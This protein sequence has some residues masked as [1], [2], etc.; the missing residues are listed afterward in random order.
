MKAVILAGGRGERLRPIT[1]TRPKP[2]VP[3][4]ARPV[5]D[6]CLSLLS[7]YGV[8]E[9]Y[10]TTHYLA[11]QIRARYG[12]R[13]FGMQMHYSLEK[14]PMGTAGAVK[15]LEDVLCREE[16]FLV[17]SG[18]ALCDFDLEKALAFHKEKKA[19]ATMILS[20]VRTPM[21]YG[22]VLSDS[23]ERIFAFS[24]KPD[25]SETFSDRVNTG[26]YIL[27]PRVLGRVPENQKFD[28]SMDLFPTLLREGYRLFGYKDDGYWCDIGKVSTLYRCNRDLL[29]GK[30]RTWFEPYGTTKTSADGKGTY[31]VSDGARIDEGAV[32]GEGTVISPGVHLAE[33][34]R[35]DGSIIMEE[36]EVGK[37]ALVR[38]AILCEKTVL[39]PGAIAM[40]GSV[41]GAESRALSG[42][43]I[44]SG[45]R[46]PPSSKI[47]SAPPFYE[48]GLVFTEEGAAKE[49]G[50][51]L[52]EKETERLGFALATARQGQIGVFWEADARARSAALHFA[53]GV[54]RGGATACLFGEA[55][56]EVASFG[57]ARFLLPSAFICSGE[58]GTLIFVLEK[59]GFPLS[60]KEVLRLGRCHEERERRTTGGIETMVPIRESYCR[61][62]REMLGE[63]NQKAVSLVGGNATL[64]REAAIKA[65]FS[66][67][68]ER[69]EKGICLEILPETLRLFVNG[70]H[71]ADTERIR[72]LLVER[73]L[74]RG[75]RRF[76]LPDT[77]PPLLREHITARGGTAEQFT[78]SH[79]TKDES[80]LRRKGSEDRWLFDVNFLAAKLLREIKTLTTKEINDLILA[81]PE[82]YVSELRYYPKEDTKAK[83]LGR[84]ARLPEEKEVRIAPGFFAI[85]IISSAYRFEA[86]LDQAM[87]IRGKINEIEKEIRGD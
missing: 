81:T 73:E 32:I 42:A 18:D 36:T 66:A 48:E 33:G 78:L 74:K 28:F 8:Q 83:L 70:E 64:L 46:I 77:T 52:D 35:V 47:L 56:R 45:S 9:A 69:K 54:V 49:S 79:T 62:L 44:L 13:A 3:V 34:C 11:E 72:L 65:G 22:V 71:L 84:L 24:E 23:G 86:A 43:A 4:L 2:L 37:N 30:A 1:D 76:F 58:K 50:I 38:D 61:A 68:N 20:S 40:T 25:W 60:R 19:D 17:M 87:E 82:V 6:Y 67:Y 14:K 75:R 51:G 10:V 16:A 15:L 41:L 26:V 7:H 27:S 5:M 55:T 57:A 21:E 53:A 31:F 85:R 39:E 80:E 12:K 59:D 29:M 63:G